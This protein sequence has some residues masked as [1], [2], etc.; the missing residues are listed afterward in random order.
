MTNIL[1][2]MVQVSRDCKLVRELEVIL[3]EKLDDSDLKTF[4]RW[5]QVV[6]DDQNMAVKKART[7]YPFSGIR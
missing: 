7:S 3:K 2:K 4:Q 5:L 6:E 1:P